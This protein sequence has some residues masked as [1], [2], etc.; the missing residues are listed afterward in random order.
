MPEYFLHHV[1]GEQEP[2]GGPG[3]QD[4]VGVGAAIDKTKF[5]DPNAVAHTGLVL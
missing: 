4:F 5:S 1:G 2:V 3:P